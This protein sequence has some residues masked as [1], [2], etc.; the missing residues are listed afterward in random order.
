MES[1]HRSKK[2][3]EKL[4]YIGKIMKQGKKNIINMQIPE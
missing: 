1:Y 4:I 2:T 3:G